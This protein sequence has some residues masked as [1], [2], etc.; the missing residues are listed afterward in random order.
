MNSLPIPTNKCKKLFALAIL[1][2]CSQMA[3]A[4]TNDREADLRSLVAAEREFSRASAERGTRAAF[5]A[6]LADDGIIF[7]PSPTRGKPLWLS[8]KDAP[9]S[10]TWTPIRAD[11]SAAGDLGYTTGP[12][13][14]R[15]SK[16]APVAGNGYY[17]S[18]W[19]RDVTGAGAW[20]VIIDIG[21][22]NAKP[23]NQPTLAFAPAAVERTSFKKIN[24]EAERKKLLETEEKFELILSAGKKDDGLPEFLGR[25]LRA[26]RM[27]GFPITEKDAVI[28][29]FRA[30]QGKLFSKPAGS[31]ISGSGDL[32][33]IY[34]TYEI[35][36]SAA[37]EAVETGSFVRVWKRG[38]NG[39]WKMAADVMHA[40]PP[41]NRD[42]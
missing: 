17:F 23:P 4:Q 31:G 33:Y 10:L 41:K 37:T 2:F 19:R 21:T 40:A 20:K 12:F 6:F 27:N 39:K 35:K 36:E 14:F 22:R 34:G 18:I 16:D 11:V 13:E 32:A 8:R 38:K 29:D 5:V 24:L 7:N 1:V 9:G 25:Q 28:A 30:K 3:A 26:H 42:K 15:Q